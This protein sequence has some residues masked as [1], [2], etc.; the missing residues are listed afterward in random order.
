MQ[1]LCRVSVDKVAVVERGSISADAKKIVDERKWSE[2]WIRSS[3]WPNCG[4]CAP[5]GDRESKTLVFTNGIF[6]LLHLGHVRYL[7][8]ARSLGDALVVGLNSDAS[9]RRLKGNNPAFDPPGTGSAGSLKNL[10]SD[11]KPLVAKLNK[12]IKCV[13]LYSLLLII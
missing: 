12:Y 6:D 7:Q 3:A 1:A 13:G 2:A 5:P 8:A 9:T 4:P 10:S 11:I